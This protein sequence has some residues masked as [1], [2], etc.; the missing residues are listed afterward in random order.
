MPPAFA[1]SQDQT[2]RFIP[3][4]NPRP[5]KPQDQAT[6]KQKPKPPPNPNTNLNPVRHADINKRYPTKQPKSRPAQKIPPPTSHDARK[7]QARAPVQQKPKPLTKGPNPRKPKPQTPETTHHHATRTVQT[8]T[9]RHRS[10]NTIRPQPKTT[11]AAQAT[12]RRQRIPSKTRFIRSMNS[13]PKAEIYPNISRSVKAYLGFA[14]EHVN[15]VSDL[16]PL[17]PAPTTSYWK[18]SLS[19]KLSACTD[20]NEIPARQPCIESAILRFRSCSV[21]AGPDLGLRPPQALSR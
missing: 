10:R 18:Q 20:L 7:A 13:Y 15:D 14:F 17:R 16:G 5:Q 3:S 11:R 19:R 21:T 2:L 1:L 4:P 8:K 12:G 9:P 6:N